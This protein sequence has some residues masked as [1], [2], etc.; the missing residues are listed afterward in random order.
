M[1][2]IWYGSCVI[3]GLEK[4]REGVKVLKFVLGTAGSGKTYNLIS[5]MNDLVSGT[6]K[7][8]LFLVPEQAS[9]ECEKELLK[10]LG[11]QKANKVKVLS[12]TR[13]CSTILSDLGGLGAKIADDGTRLILLFEALESLKEDLEVYSKFSGIG[14][15]KKLIKDISEL[16]QAALT[17]ERLNEC[18]QRVENQTLRLKL[19]D[20]AKIMSAYDLMLGKKFVDPEDVAVITANKATDAAWFKDKY[21]FVDGFTGF[22][23]AQY[24]LLEAAIRHSAEVVFSF[25][26][27]GDVRK[28]DTEIFANIK[29]EIEY[30]KRIAK[31]CVEVDKPLVLTKPVAK[32]DELLAL[33]S[34]LRGNQVDYKTAPDNIKLCPCM[35]PRDEAEFIANEICRQVREQGR[36]WRDFLIITGSA[37]KMEKTV[38][39]VMKKYNIPCFVS[40]NKML[41]TLPIARFVSSALCTIK[42]GYKTEDVLS[43]LKSGLTDITDDEI[44]N[45]E[46]Y[47][48]L[49][50]IKGKKWL[51]EWDMSPFG[52]E[53]S[54]ASEQEKKKIL[55]EINDIRNRTI[56]PIMQLAST[57]HGT[58]QDMVKGIYNFLVDCKTAEKLKEYATILDNQGEYATAA[59]QSTSWDKLMTVLDR[60]TNSLQDSNMN[61]SRFV[62][63]LSAA[64]A[65]ETVGEI[66]QRTDEVIFGTAERL[67]PLRPAVVFVMS[68]NIGVF[69]AGISN[70]G[71]FT[72]SERSELE[73]INVPLPDRYLAAAVEQN[74]LFYTSICSASERVYVTYSRI[75]QGAELKPS[76]EVTKI[77][78]SFGFEKENEAAVYDLNKI[79]CVDFERPNPAFSHL[80]MHKDSNDVELVSL[81]QA[82]SN[83]DGYL[84]KLSLIDGS[85]KDKDNFISSETAKTLYGDNIYLSASKLETFYSC[86]FSYFCRYGLKAS[87]KRK[88]SLDSMVRG[89]I[90]HYVFERVL[91]KYQG[92]F[93]ELDSKTAFEE[94]NITVDEYFEKI[95]TDKSTLDAASRYAISCLTELICDVLTFI[96]RDFTQNEFSPAAYELEI[97]NKCQV[98]PLSVKADECTV[99]ITG[100]I[101]RVDVA[102][103]NDE[104]AVRIIDYK[105]Y[106]KSFNL[107]HVLE[108]RNMQML[109][110]LCAV[111]ESNIKLFDSPKPAGI[112]YLQALPTAKQ[113]E[114]Q[115]KPSAFLTNDKDVLS[116][117]DKNLSGEFIPVKTTKL[118]NVD[119]RSPVISPE[120]FDVVFKFI[121]RKIAQMANE[122]T[123]GKISIDPLEVGGKS[124][125]EYCDFRC[126][127]GKENQDPA[128]E[129]EFE[130]LSKDDALQ[131]MKDEVSN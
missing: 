124:G 21:L 37:A 93:S 4:T 35:T 95:G 58:A 51:S 79:S 52:I 100:K 90:A 44:N 110:Y 76:T 29:K 17:P 84:E 70:S 73:R 50:N 69:P 11:T 115:L 89:T 40:E 86:P 109:I 131:M 105:S 30:I 125:C 24:M 83:T 126:V 121:K 116:K 67:R 33:E 97:G 5:Q 92:R 12:F 56:K 14:F 62:E 25:T 36:R 122:I 9:F 123:S 57:M 20:I 7:E 66:P 104:T 85:K 49:W 2:Q 129:S 96:A 77:R 54:Y 39:S 47:V 27:D 106:V 82:L 98:S 68:A 16:K 88:A 81:R 65:D 75:S 119:K 71:I 34:F 107:A 111:V 45:L 114:L 60:I 117:M 19:L 118:G 23:R 8:V 113:E 78:E 91:A 101:D 38:A 130:K 128:R 1:Y 28:N 41:G 64:F 120:D 94:A 32:A 112:L 26:S 13:L 55:D 63:I 53:E 72:L 80:A 42:G 15:A 10:T 108:G 48:Y 59:L 87:P 18:A 74:Y 3:I 127:C 61:L 43:Y 103:D 99:N 31:G 102:A 6:D 46:N 22:T